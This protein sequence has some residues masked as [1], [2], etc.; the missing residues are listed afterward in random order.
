[1]YV[2]QYPVVKYLETY[3]QSFVV[4]VGDVITKSE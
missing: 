1:M 3:L 2:N 4:L